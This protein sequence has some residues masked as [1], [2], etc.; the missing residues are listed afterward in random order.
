MSNTKSRWGT[1]KSEDEDIV[2]ESGSGCYTQVSYQG[3]PTPDVL[4]T[5]GPLSLM[6]N[7]LT[8]DFA[9]VRKDAQGLPQAVHALDTPLIRTGVTS[10]VAEIR[11]AVESHQVAVKHG[12]NSNRILNN[13]LE[14]LKQ[15]KE[16]LEAQ[17]SLAVKKIAELQDK[18]TETKSRRSTKASR[19]R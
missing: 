8:G 5:N 13:Q 14:V 9:F 7:N 19:K 10:L 15:E 1:F 18:P 2:E 4:W 6:Y 3:E 17:L 11:N 16:E 12:N